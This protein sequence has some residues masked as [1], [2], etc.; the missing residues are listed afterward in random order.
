MLL[1]VAFQAELP[2]SQGLDVDGV[3][4]VIDSPVP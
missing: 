1:L 4:T 2:P 3:M